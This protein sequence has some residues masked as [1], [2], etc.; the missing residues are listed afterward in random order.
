[1]IKKPLTIG[2]VGLGYGRAHLIG[3]RAAGCEVAAI[4]QRDSESARALAA[5]YD[6]PATYSGWAEMI[7]SEKPDIVAIATPPVLHMPIFRAAMKAGA[8]VV[9]EKPLAMNREEALE[10]IDLARQSG[11]VGITAFNW[12]YPAAMQEF[13]KR[14]TAGDI[15]RVFHVNARWL[16]GQWA[17]E[18]AAA[19][20]RMNREQAGHGAMGDQGVHLIDMIRWLFGE[21]A[22]VT[23]SAGIA[24][25][26]RKA[27]SG[28]DS[29]AEDHCSVLGELESGTQVA[30]TVSRVAHGLNEHSI[31]AYGTDGALS[32]RVA[33]SGKDWY[34]GNLRAAKPGALFE[35]VPLH[36]DIPGIEACHDLVETVG[37]ATV[38]PMA[39]EMLSAID[40]GK[41]PSPSLEDG[42][43]AQ[44]VLDAVL[45]SL[46]TGRWQMPKA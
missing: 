1:M 35:D 8:H 20:W 7:E 39:R 21:F 6:V 11:R 14:I 32:L 4:C 13:H 22:R 30:L 2:I 16:N 38:A 40:Q 25:T 43:R 37:L 9:C 19:T 27:P 34:V 29:D 26:S 42:L 31:E 10:M 5:K 44:S 33:R 46:R 24:Y 18:S 36:V 3:F 23:A 17:S 45:E 41:A 28:T 15:G 12:R